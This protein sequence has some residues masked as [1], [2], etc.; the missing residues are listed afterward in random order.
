MYSFKDT[1]EEE[2]PRLR[3]GQ[4]LVALS[5]GMVELFRDFLGKGPERC[6]TYWAGSD[7]LLIMLDG[8]YTVAERTL[9]EAGRGAAVRE[10]RMALQQILASRMKDTVE[11]LTGRNVV[12]FLSASHQDPDLSAE[13]FVLEPHEPDTPAG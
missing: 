4:L 6:K 11:Q 1:T 13:I 10:S 5:D 2:G 7:T 3:G 12:A 9:F 8:G